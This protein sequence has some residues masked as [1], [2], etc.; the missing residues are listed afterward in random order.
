MLEQVVNSIAQ[1]FPPEAEVL[2]QTTPA[3]Q[4]AVSLLAVAMPI[5]VSQGLCTG[6]YS[7]KG[8]EGETSSFLQQKNRIQQTRKVF[9]ASNLFMAL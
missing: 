2:R 5:L 4:A 6:T 7:G 9:M 3:F 8:T 1:K